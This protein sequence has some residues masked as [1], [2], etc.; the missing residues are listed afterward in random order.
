[1]GRVDGS[2]ARLFSDWELDEMRHLFR[3]GWSCAALA[4]QY[5]VS[6]RTIE[7]RLAEMGELI[8]KPRIAAGRRTA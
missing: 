7:R 4:C 8:K 2:Y 1:M 5:D 6:A 3:S